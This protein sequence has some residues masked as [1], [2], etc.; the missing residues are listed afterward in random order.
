MPPARVAGTM[1]MSVS[2]GFAK[3]ATFAAT[4]NPSKKEMVP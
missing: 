4:E 2:D 1:R 3:A